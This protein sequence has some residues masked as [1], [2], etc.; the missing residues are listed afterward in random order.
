MILRSQSHPLLLTVAEKT[1]EYQQ[2]L[3]FFLK[4]VWR[5]SSPLATL[6]PPTISSI[7]SLINPLKGNGFQGFFFT[8]D[9]HHQIQT[10]IHFF[11]FFASWILYVK[12]PAIIW[13]VQYSGL[14]S[15]RTRFCGGNGNPLPN[16]FFQNELFFFIDVHIFLKMTILLDFGL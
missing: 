13:N 7:D 10:L 14:L 9:I 2:N 11:V 1:A 4:K 15:T 5:T 6:L 3:S 8:Y 12:A 16:D